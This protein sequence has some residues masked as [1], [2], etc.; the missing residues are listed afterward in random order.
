VT[1]DPTNSIFE[2][3]GVITYF[4]PCAGAG[5]ATF[6]ASPVVAFVVSAAGSL[7]A[8]KNINPERI[9]IAIPLRIVF[10]LLKTDI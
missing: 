6:A 9:V 1:F 7:H 4:C 5:E 3:C 10:L 2:F 8:V